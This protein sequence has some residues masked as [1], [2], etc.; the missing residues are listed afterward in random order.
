MVVVM[1]ESVSVATA[2]I[3]GFKGFGSTRQRI[4][5]WGK[6]RYLERNF[7]MVEREYNIILRRK[8]GS[9]LHTY[10]ESHTPKI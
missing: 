4:L 7:R 1:T 10:K 2:V 8:R 9:C 5:K 6:R 3:L